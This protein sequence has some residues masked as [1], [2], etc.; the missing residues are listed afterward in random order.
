MAGALGRR[1]PTIWT[2]VE[3][4]PYAALRPKTVA[5]VDKVLKLPS[6]HLTH[7][8]GQEGS[9]VGHAGVLERAVTNRAQNRLA[10]L[11]NP[12]R[13]YD[14]LWAW[15]RAKEIDPF[16]DTNPGDDNGTLVS[17]FYDVARDLGM[18]R[19]SVDGVRI[20]PTTGR[21][22]VVDPAPVEPK[23]EEGVAAT[24]WATSVDEIRT[25]IA[26][27]TA[28][29][30]G[31]NWYSDFDQPEPRFGRKAEPEFWIGQDSNT[32][33]HLRGGHAVLLYGA[34]DKREAFRLKNSWGTSYPLVWLPYKT[35]ERLLEEWGEAALVT[36]R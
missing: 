13:R 33:G 34:S 35:M 18:R 23:L 16:P 32:L 17:S 2:H 20:D 14:P 9:C 15:D 24:R 1:T 26:S 31:V 3:R 30:I 27:R 11:L 4:Y 5:S 28:V 7:D 12:E 29:T 10:S 6:W 19:I 25:A 21:P 22:I 36:D 8:Q